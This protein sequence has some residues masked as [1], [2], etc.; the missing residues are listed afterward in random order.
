MPIQQ[1]LMIAITV[2]GV[3]GIV[4]VITAIVG[5]LMR[6]ASRNILVGFLIVGIVMIIQAVACNVSF[7]LG[8]MSS[9]IN[10]RPAGPF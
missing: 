3:G 8:Q 5:A 1:P 6:L 2:L 9:I 4:L 7:Q 10:N